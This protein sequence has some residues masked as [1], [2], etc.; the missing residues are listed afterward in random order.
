MKIHDNHTEEFSFTQEQVVAFAEISGDKNPIHLDPEFAEKSF[1]KTTIMH[2]FLTGSVFSKIIGMYFPGEGSIYLK[3]DLSFHRP[4]F[5]DN[6]YV[7]TVSITDIDFD[8][9]H[10]V[11][12]TQI[13]DKNTGK[14]T[15]SGSALVFYPPMTK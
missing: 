7:A 13:T 10:L 11:L 2:G 6:I 3:Q 9:K 1:F 4:M 12:N 15:I 14:P 5:V 8:K